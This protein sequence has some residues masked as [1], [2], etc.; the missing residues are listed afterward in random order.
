MSCNDGVGPSRKIPGL[1]GHWHLDKDN[2]QCPTLSIQFCRNDGRLWA[3]SITGNKACAV[4]SNWPVM[5]TGSNE[6]LGS[7]GWGGQQLGLGPKAKEP[8]P[9]GWTQAR[10]Q[11][12]KMWGLQN[13]SDILWKKM[14]A[15]NIKLISKY[16]ICHRLFLKI[17]TKGHEKV[18]RKLENN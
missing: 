17:Y 18:Q 12:L 6:G 13:R 4:P 10:C 16:V 5:T 15:N 3:V 9:P 14:C 8:T 1:G 7:G 11:G 2:W